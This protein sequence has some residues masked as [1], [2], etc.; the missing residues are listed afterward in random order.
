MLQKPE[1]GGDDG[2]R[3]RDRI[4]RADCARETVN[5]WKLMDNTNPLCCE[6]FACSTHMRINYGGPLTHPVF[7]LLDDGRRNRDRIFRADCARET[8]NGWKLMGY[9]HA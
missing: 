3:N 6:L 8:V 1:I 2:R 7:S 5:G 4:F 9:E